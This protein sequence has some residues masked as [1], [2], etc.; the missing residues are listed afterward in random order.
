MVTKN[1]EIALSYL[2]MEISNAG[3]STVRK[4]VLAALNKAETVTI[5]FNTFGLEIDPSRQTVTLIQDW[6]ACQ[7]EVF[8]APVFVELIE[9]ARLRNR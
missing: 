5:D 6:F 7:P 3:V 4:R 9:S 8:S 2:D 1:R